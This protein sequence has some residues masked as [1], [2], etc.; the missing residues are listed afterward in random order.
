M[1]R[2]AIRRGNQKRPKQSVVDRR[3]RRREKSFL[4]A[5]GSLERVLYVKGLI[6]AVPGCREFSENAHTDNGGTGRKADADRVANLCRGHHRTR[7]DSLHNLGSKEAFARVHG[8]DLDEVAAKIE[9]AWPT[10]STH[11]PTQE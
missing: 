1:K 5:Y 3:K 7:D 10:T 9:Q 11:T 2:S 6:C 4:R 8:V